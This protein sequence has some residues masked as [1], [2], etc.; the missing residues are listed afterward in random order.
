MSAQQLRDRL[1]VI[2]GCLAAPGHVQPGRHHHQSHR[3]LFQQVPEALAVQATVAQQRPFDH[4]HAGCL[5]QA[6]DR[7]VTRRLDHH[8]GVLE[9]QYDDQYFQHTA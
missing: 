2:I 1:P 6:Q 4:L 9:S 5:E 3:L 8:R 7:P